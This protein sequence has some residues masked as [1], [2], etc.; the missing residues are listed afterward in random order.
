VSDTRLELFDDG[1]VFRR[2]WNMYVPLGSLAEAE[3]PPDPWSRLG[4]PA[5]PLR[6]AEDPEETAYFL[7]QVA[8]WGVQFPGLALAERFDIDD[9]V[10][11]Q[12]IETTP[13]GRV[14]LV[15]VDRPADIP[16]KIGWQ[17]AVNHFMD[18]DGPTLLSVMMRSWEDRFGA[19]LFRLGF[20][21]MQFLVR[22]PPRSEASAQAV[23][24]EHFAFAGQDSVESIRMHTSHITNN[25]T[26]AFW[27]D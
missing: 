9:E 1:E 8:P 3:R 17:G 6:T 27:W 21:T 19:Q 10:Y 15:A 5:P 7:E 16:H 20:D 24:A 23:A 4:L 26:W 2:R 13:S 14:G 22:R 25:P 18:G 11:R 12:A